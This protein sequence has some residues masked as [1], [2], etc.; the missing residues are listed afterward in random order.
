MSLLAYLPLSLVLQYPYLAFFIGMLVLGDVVFVPAIYLSAHGSLSVWSVLGLAFLAGMISDAW[1]YVLG[2][3]IPMRRISSWKFVEKRE[4]IRA[5]ISD[6]VDTHAQLM[7]VVSKF[8]YGTRTLM[9]LVAGAKHISI[10][11]Y[12][13]ANAFGH[14]LWFGA[15]TA[16]AHIVRAS[17]GSFRET[18]VGT[19]IAFA[20][21]VVVF[22][23][24]Q[25]ALSRFFKRKYHLENGGGKG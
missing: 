20:L 12:A 25:I 8:T 16:I 13:S 6:L 7:I 10:L 19:S 17:L 9:Q 15:A 22:L 24:G 14:I 18:L 5:K 11:R 4:H 23:V 1:W 2:R 3:T 21:F